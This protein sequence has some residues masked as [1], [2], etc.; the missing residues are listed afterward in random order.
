MLGIVRPCSRALSPAQRR[1]WLGHLCGMCLALRDGHGQL[2]RVATSYDGVVVSALVAAQSPAS[3]EQRRAGPCPLRGLRPAD[4]TTGAGAQLAAVAALALA[5]AK[6]RDHVADRDGVFARRPIAAAAGRL[7][8]AWERRTAAAGARLGLDTAVLT[9]AVVRQPVLE[10]ALRAGDPVTDA[11]VPTEDAAAAVFAHAARLA[12]AGSGLPAAVREGNAAAL[13][14]AGRGFGRLA[15]L[16]D[17]VEDLDEDRRRGAWN[18]L[19]ATGTDL[20]T[21]RG[22][23]DAAVQD[24]RDALR[25][26][27]FADGALVHRLLAHDLG[28]AVTRVFGAGSQPTDPGHHKAPPSGPGRPPGRSLLPG[29]LAA[30]GLFCTCRMCCAEY[31]GPWSRKP[32]QGCCRHF[33]CCDCCSC[34]C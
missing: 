15:H 27:E 30:V 28:H 6:V 13:A 34:D 12:G 9:A 7:A 5:G 29:C 22:L 21:A 1:A 25:A 10:A 17:A 23:C 11:T 16:L 4:V 24:V 2:A 19:L 31:E 18:P 14:E 26:V 3:A 20:A 32:R 8:A 33:D